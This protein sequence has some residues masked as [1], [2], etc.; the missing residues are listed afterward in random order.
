MQPVSFGL[1]R[2][3]LLLSMDS[4]SL[5]HYWIKFLECVLVTF[6][7]CDKNIIT[8]SYLEK[9]EFILAYGSK[10]LGQNGR[11]GMA[12]ESKL[13]DHISTSHRKQRG[14]RV[15]QD[16]K[17][18]RPTF[19]CCASSPDAATSEGSQTC[20]STGDQGLKCRKLKGGISHPNNSTVLLAALS[21]ILNQFKFLRE[22]A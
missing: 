15:G 8:K 21:F 14:E 12:D 5:S 18:S 7:C 20:P 4:F 19:Q 6:C 1:V 17:T 10:G 22:K 16:Y 9:R 13:A 11:E 2:T 3:S